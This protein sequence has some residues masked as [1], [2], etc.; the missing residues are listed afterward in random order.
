MAKLEAA[1]LKGKFRGCMVGTLMGDCLGAPFECDEYSE[2]GK[3]TIQRYFDQ[4]ESGDNLRGSLE[5][6][7]LSC[8]HIETV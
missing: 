8:T 6:R 4:L 1:I 7:I 2:G 5:I 3:L